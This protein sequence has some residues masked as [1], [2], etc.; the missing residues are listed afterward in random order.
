MLIPIQA[1]LAQ[2]DLPFAAK[3]KFD[4]K[5]LLRV[6]TEWGYDMIKPLNAV[7]FEMKITKPGRVI[8]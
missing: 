4:A 2:N 5:L 1:S 6:A 8:Y 3:V 7:D